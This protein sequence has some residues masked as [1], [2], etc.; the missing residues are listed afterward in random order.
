MNKAELLKRLEDI[1][2]EDY[3]SPMKSRVRI[4]TDRIEFMN[5]GCFPKPVD[6]LIKSDISIPRNPIIAKLFRLVK[7][8]ENAGFGFDKMINGWK[9]Y[10][11]KAP[12]FQNETDYSVVTFFEDEVS[13]D[14]SEKRSEKK[15]GEKGRRKP[16]C[17]SNTNTFSSKDKA[18]HVGKRAGRTC[19]NFQPEN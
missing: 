9:S 15:V 6:E 13:I 2:W 1:E 5:P 3:F 18:K 16:D 8:A 10:S 4:F 17:E 7:L 14:R 12:V 19:R 11:S